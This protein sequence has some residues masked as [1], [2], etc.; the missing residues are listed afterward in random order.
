MQISMGVRLS[1][2]TVTLMRNVLINQAAL[3]VFAK[4][5]SKAMVWTAS[6]IVSDFHIYT[7]M[8]GMTTRSGVYIII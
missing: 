6:R 3:N 2:T 4:M 7:C 5:V 1:T 8:H